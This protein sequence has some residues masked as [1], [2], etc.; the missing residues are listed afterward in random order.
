MA[1]IT[2]TP[3]DDV[4]RGTSGPDVIDAGDGNDAI[5][6]VG[7][8][9]DD[10]TTGDIVSTGGGGGYVQLV[11]FAPSHVQL[12]SGRDIVWIVSTDGRQ[13][14]TELV[15][16][17]SVVA[18][19][20]AVIAN[21]QAGAGGDVI[22]LSSVLND[23]FDSYGW[24]GLANPF[25]TGHLVLSQVGAD[26][27][28]RVDASPGGPATDVKLLTLLNVQASQLTGDNFISSL[29]RVSSGGFYL[30]PGGDPGFSPDGSS[31]PNTLLGTPSDLHSFQGTAGNDTI[32]PSPSFRNGGISGGFGHD[33]IFGSSSADRLDGGEGND[34]ISGGDGADFIQ[35]LNGNDTLYGENGDDELRGEAGTDI[36]IGA[37]GSDKLDG[38]DSDDWLY[39]GVGND[40]LDGGA[41]T[42]TAVF[43]GLRSAYSATSTGGVV[44]VTGPDGV[45]TLSNIELLKFS[46]GVFALA[47]LLN[48]APPVVS[49]P[50]TLSPLAEDAS[51]IITATALLANATDANSDTLSITSLTVS[52]GSLTANANGTWTF[53]PAADDDTAVTFSYGVSDGVMTTAATANLD[54]T[55]VNDAPVALPGV[56]S[57]VGPV[58]AAVGASDI[59]S[60]SLNYSLV[61]GPAHGQLNLNANGTFTYQAAGGYVG[62]DTFIF[63]ASDGSSSSTATMTLHVFPPN[64][65]VLTGGGSSDTLATGDGND[66]LNG[67][68]GNDTLSGGGGNDVL[69]GGQGD[70]VMRGGGGDDTYIVNA[71]GDVVTENPGEGI[72]EVSSGLSYT[73]PDNVENLVLLYGG[74]TF[75]YGNALN[76]RITGNG[77]D[78]YLRGG[79]GADILSGGGGAD[80]LWGQTGI[81]QLIGGG[82]A[83][84]F[85]FNTT[86]EIG[87]A[88]E[89]IVDFS[90][91]EGDKID[92]RTIDANTLTAGDQAFAYIDSALFH[93]IAGE[94]RVV[95][96]GDTFSVQGDVNGDGRA[97]FTLMVNIKPLAAD[98]LL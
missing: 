69:D 70:D 51:R 44:K 34:E 3:Y 74:S 72:D 37:Q 22:A 85:L 8:N 14:G 35:G 52:R 59:D 38:G 94:L 20:R 64:N 41:G 84:I 10:A 42:D 78:N 43:A 67:L 24:D 83:D 93:R 77:G 81:D 5:L 97:D 17:W 36:L 62:D 86:G 56:I 66:W 65:Q 2:G 25:A 63:Q 60:P 58:T 28:L 16:S 50:V 31:F 95:A 27:V 87:N 21:F 68:A 13:I 92:L 9:L 88:G 90:S 46:D 39:G 53:Q 98:F 11:P 32:R 29:N 15:R 23:L 73:L 40:T 1:T 19:N 79:G 18:D 89:T 30:G 80:T 57:T 71:R 75:G 61:T 4:L 55:P 12:G 7:A 48:A 49:G 96:T 6:G 45:D 33:T 47:S 26:A 82:G 54:L 91:A 76:N